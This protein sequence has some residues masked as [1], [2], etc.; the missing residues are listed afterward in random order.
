[1]VD[2]V[3]LVFRPLL[4]HRQRPRK[5]LHA[6]DEVNARIRP[7]WGVAFTIRGDVDQ[8]GRTSP[9]FRRIVGEEDLRLHVR[10][11]SAIEQSTDLAGEGISFRSV[12]KRK[13]VGRIKD[14]D[15]RP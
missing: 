4:T 10:R 2:Y 3:D 9:V 1:M 12:S 15:V 8:R 11:A 7:D 6:G 14:I 5:M 13:D